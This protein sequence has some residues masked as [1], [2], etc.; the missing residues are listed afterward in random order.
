MTKC[1]Q[2]RE[3][4]PVKV[5]QNV[6]A[7]FEVISDEK[8]GGVAAGLATL[9]KQIELYGKMGVSK[10][11][12]DLHAVFRSQAGSLLLTDEA[13]NR[14]TD[15]PAGNPNKEIIQKLATS[16]MSIELCA[17]TMEHHQWTG[18]DILPEAIIVE[19]ALTRLIDLQLQGYA[20]VKL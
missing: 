6:R 1:I 4:V 18:A 14:F 3:P 16:G 2:T 13:Y 20:Y 17:Q 12:L 7:A 8:R 10:A 19:S 11:G 5:V 15:D 9:E